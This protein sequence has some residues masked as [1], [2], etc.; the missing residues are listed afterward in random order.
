M[1]KKKNKIKRK[2]RIRAKVRGTAEKPRLV[3]FKSNLHIYAQIINDDSGKTLVSAS[4]LEIK[5]SMTKKEIAFMVGE[6]LAQKAQRFSLGKIKK[7]VFDRAGF[8]F[9]GR[10]RQL[11]EGARKAGLSF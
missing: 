3:V 7:V 4:D 10:I 11:A 8:K 6:K 9:H 2:R 5:K 1:N